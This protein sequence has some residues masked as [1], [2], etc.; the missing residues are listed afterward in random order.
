MY[1]VKLPPSLRRQRPQDRMNR[2]RPRASPPLLRVVDA[3]S[4]HFKVFAYS[5]QR[6]LALYPSRHYARRSLPSLRNL[7]PHE[8]RH[9]QRELFQGPPSHRLRPVRRQPLLQHLRR[10]AERQRQMLQNVRAR[11]LSLRPPPPVVCRHARSR[12]IDLLSRLCQPGFHRS[13]SIVTSSCIKLVQQCALPRVTMQM[14]H[15][16]R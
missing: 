8:Q 5:P 10:P 1:E 9:L 4:H 14:N 15:S 3:R 12:L 6:L 2:D 13:P 7:I 16:E 11:P